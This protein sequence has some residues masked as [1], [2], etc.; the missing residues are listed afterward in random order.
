MWLLLGGSGSH[1]DPSDI[2][3]QNKPHPVGDLRHPSGKRSEQN[4]RPDDGYTSLPP[5]HCTTTLSV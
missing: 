5:L 4:H 3:R 2:D 1:Q